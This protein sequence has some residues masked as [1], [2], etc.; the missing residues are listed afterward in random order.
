M[1]F[2]GRDAD[3]TTTTTPLKTTTPLAPRFRLE[4]SQKILLGLLA[5]EIAVFAVIGT[6][7][8]RWPMRSR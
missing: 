2:I 7:F 1:R 6:N 4:P 5:F 3:L 8:F